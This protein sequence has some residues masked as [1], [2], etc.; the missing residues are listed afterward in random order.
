[1]LYDINHAYMYIY[2]YMRSIK[3]KNNNNSINLDKKA[4]AIQNL[5]V[6]EYIDETNVYLIMAAIARHG[7]IYCNN[8]SIFVPP[9]LLLHSLNILAPMDF[10][11]KV[12]LES[13]DI[14]LSLIILKY[15]Q[16][17]PGKLLIDIE[18]FCSG[19]GYSNSM[20][21]RT[22]ERK[23]LEHGL[24]EIDSAGLNGNNNFELPRKITKRG[25]Y[26]INES[27]GDI[28]ILHAYCYE[29]YFPNVFFRN[30]LIKAYD[31]TFGEYPSAQVINVLSLLK[32]LQIQANRNNLVTL[33]FFS[34]K[35]KNTLIKFMNLLPYTEA[36]DIIN[37]FDK[38]MIKY[39]DNSFNDCPL[40]LD[41]LLI[42]YKNTDMTERQF[43]NLLEKCNF[44]K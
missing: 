22:L 8:M 38:F 5:L 24:I 32:L 13:K 21:I 3:E 44:A 11:S 20:T 34:R 14:L 33:N 10:K 2:H 26:L 17:K 6:A 18:D 35:L 30:K 16:Q 9:Y 40:T 39:S 36:K 4:E 42:Q 29:I 31:N 27:L 1:M 41:E 19:L 7:K 15:I 23:L 43:K 37:S 25:E 12:G 28:Q